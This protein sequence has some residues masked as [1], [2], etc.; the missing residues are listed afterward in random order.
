MFDSSS[1][2]NTDKCD[3]RVQIPE[4]TSCVLNSMPM[5]VVAFARDL[6]IVQ[7]NDRAEEMLDLSD[8]IDTTLSS[9]T[10]PKVWS[11]WKSQLK[12]ILNS[13]QTAT[14]NSVKYST[15]IRTRLLKIIISPLTPAPDNSVQGGIAL[16]EDITGI[17]SIA[18]EISQVERHAALGKIAGKV[19]HELNNPMD[20][21]LRYISLSIKA[22]ENKQSEKPIEYLGHCKT[23]LMRMVRIIGELLE[24]SRGR[25]PALHAA[26]IKKIVTEAVKVMEPKCGNLKINICPDEKMSDTTFR[27]ENLFQVF[28]NLIK[29]AAD[30]MKGTGTLDIKIS[31]D[32]DQ[33]AIDFI[34]NG[35]GI[36]HEHTTSI[37]EPFFTTKGDA[38]GTG[39]GL[40]ICKDIIEKYNG[41]I[42][43]KNNQQGGCRFTVT[44]PLK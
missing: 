43:V 36:P 1:K 21:I 31:G 25:S 22:I 2:L 33:I 9:G 44:L 29:N 3:I 11:D 19:A 35:P 6:T 26:P 32:Q 16:I 4:L 12:D 17:D 38:G 20:G 7:A 14:F 40:A 5:A 41:T 18:N 28:C 24:F 39:L 8:N 37:F 27:G 13:S 42:L 10:D 30:A 34:D 23:G 15:A